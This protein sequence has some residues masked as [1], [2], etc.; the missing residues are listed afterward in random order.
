MN[1]TWFTSREEK[2]PKIEKRQSPRAFLTVAV[3]L[4]VGDTII[5]AA[6]CA[7]ISETGMLIYTKHE[8]AME[9]QGV[10]TLTKRCGERRYSFS[11]GFLVVRSEMTK[12]HGHA[13]GVQFTRLFEEDEK[14]LHIIV[15]YHLG[16]MV[17]ERIVINPDNLDGLVFKV[18]ETD[19]ELEQAFR[20]VHDSYV[21]EK[22]MQPDP[23]GIR[24]SLYHAMPYTTTFIGVRNG[25]VLVA[26]SLFMDSPL[27]LP[28]DSLYKRELDEL[29]SKYRLIAEIGAFAVRPGQKN[30]DTNVALHLQKLVFK[31]TLE[32]LRIDDIVVTINPKHRLFYKHILHMDQFGEEKTYERVNNNPA[33]ALRLNIRTTREVFNKEY[34]GLPDNKN[35]YNFFFNIDSEA[36]ICPH[37]EKPIVVWDKGRLKRFFTE[38]TSIFDAAPKEKLDMVLGNYPDMKHE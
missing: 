13:I 29:R 27:G 22:Y 11:A 7:N 18:A 17:K 30:R 5:Q 31:Y 20:V 2:Q 12:R 35:L 4:E 25:E 8:F 14:N 1:F 34:F 21:A 37:D 36:I 24:L 26:T 9:T 38:K 3:T 10:V 15:D 28:M 16:L 23:C 6:E 33:I 32:R 19:D